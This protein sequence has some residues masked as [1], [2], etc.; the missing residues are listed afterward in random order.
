MCFECPILLPTF[1]Y[2]VPPF[3]RL[4]R[5]FLAVFH[6]KYV[7]L[8]LTVFSCVFSCIC[9]YFHV[10]SLYFHGISLA[11]CAF[12]SF[13]L[14]SCAFTCFHVPPRAFMYLHLF[15]RAFTYFHEYFQV[16]SRIFMSFIWYFMLSCATTCF[17]LFS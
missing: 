8:Q 12:I 5:P 17:H 1:C 9:T 14:F 16:L 11:S 6:Q 7:L 13:H 10:F 4:S 15:S 3:A 2:K